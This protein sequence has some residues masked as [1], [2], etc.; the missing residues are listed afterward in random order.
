MPADLSG[1]CCVSFCDVD[2]FCTYW[3][4]SG[5]GTTQDCGGADLDGSGTVD[6]DDY[7]SLALQWLSYN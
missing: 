4:E 2:T 1:D 6:F 3:L 7:R 5:C